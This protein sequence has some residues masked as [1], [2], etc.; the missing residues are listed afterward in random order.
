MFLRSTDWYIVAVSTLLA[1]VSLLWAA[2]A[3]GVR[4]RLGLGMFQYRDLPPQLRWRTAVPHW[5]MAKAM[6]LTWFGGVLSYRLITGRNV[7][8]ELP[9]RVTLAFVLSYFLVAKL[10]AYRTWAQLPERDEET[11]L[12]YGSRV[13]AVR[14]AAAQLRK[15]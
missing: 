11:F 9:M 10:I 3:N 15:D 14:D 8:F 5:F 1:V 4:R 12:Q 2:H 6:F 13:K 7:G